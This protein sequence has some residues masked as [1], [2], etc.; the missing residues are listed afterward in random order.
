LIVGEGMEQKALESFSSNLGVRNRVTFLG[1]RKREE[2]LELYNLADLFA[3]A[4]YSEGLPRVLIEAM[5]CGCIP[6]VTGVGDA[7]AIVIN[8]YNGFT[9]RPGDY[10][11]FC[12]RITEVLAFSAWNIETLKS[13]ARR[14]VEDG[15]D[16]VKLMK[17]MI[18]QIAAVS[19]YR[20]QVSL[21]LLR[22]QSL[23]FSEPI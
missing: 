18:D 21:T 8:G 13:K 16:G 4:S 22:Q 1:F 6:I 14:T 10:K 5:A 3:L 19:R 15:F 2:I 9:V 20:N 17:D 11:E 7:K 23:S 12:K